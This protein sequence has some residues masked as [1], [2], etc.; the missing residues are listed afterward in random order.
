M[1]AGKPITLSRSKASGR[2]RP[3]SRERIEIAALKLIE[4]DGLQSFSTRK[5][6]DALGCEAMSIYHHFPSKARLMD[7][8]LDRVLAEMELPPTDMPWLE[9]IRAMAWAIRGL[10]LARPEFFQ[11]MALHR[12]NTPGGLASL[13]AIIGAF[14][15]GGF[16]PERTARL[17]RS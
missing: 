16:D 15:D 13:E 12:M 7:A 6:A 17:F 1:Q 3:L 2:R 8:L 5:L 11:Y 9:R 10:A 4:R 14:R